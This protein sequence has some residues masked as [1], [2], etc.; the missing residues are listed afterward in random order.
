MNRT[1]FSLFELAVSIAVIVIIIAIAVPAFTYMR[2]SY[3]YSCNL[4]A[5]DSLLSS[6]RAI[7]AK[8]GKYAGVRFQLDKS[9]KQVAV[10]IVQTSNREF[11]PERL[12]ESKAICFLPAEGS[13]AAMLGESIG[14]AKPSVT[15]GSFDSNS[16]RCTVLF[17]PQGKLCCSKDVLLLERDLND[18]TDDDALDQILGP[19]GFLVPDE[20]A[21][22]SLTGVV[23]Y[24]RKKLKELQ[25]TPGTQDEVH[26][27]STLKQ[28]F[29]NVY[30]GVLIQ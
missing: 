29:I 4:P 20:N 19:K 25:A 17:L 15:S 12:K 7:A 28:N 14:V 6:A 16:T 5:I 11:V 10:L 21:D 30:S 2:N 27:L 9:G 24:D 13:R 22:T 18:T 23:L 3:E 1:G 8:E 26:Y